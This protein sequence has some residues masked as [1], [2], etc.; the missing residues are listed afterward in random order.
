MVLASGTDVT[1]RADAVAGRTMTRRGTIAA[2]VTALVGSGDGLD[3]A[4]CNLLKLAAGLGALALRRARPR[5]PSA[6]G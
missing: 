6:Q 1:H 2:V 4:G 5:A 3:I